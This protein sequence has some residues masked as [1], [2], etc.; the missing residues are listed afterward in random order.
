MRER[1]RERKRGTVKERDGKRES[2]RV[3]EA[4]APLGQF[5]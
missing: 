1:E 2:D 4:Y 3:S 5:H